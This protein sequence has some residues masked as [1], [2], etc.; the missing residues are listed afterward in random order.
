MNLLPFGSEVVCYTGIDDGNWRARNAIRTERFNLMLTPIEKGAL[1][2]LACEEGV[3]EAVA[4][5]KLL[6]AEAER[7]GLWPDTGLRRPQRAAQAGIEH[8]SPQDL[9]RSFVSDLLD[10]GVDIAPVAAIAGHAN[11]ATTARYDRRGEHAKRRAAGSLHVPY[12]ARR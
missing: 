9:R 8:T 12:S 10:S 3:P 1:V 5:R 11:V 2:R 4:L 6:H 7:R